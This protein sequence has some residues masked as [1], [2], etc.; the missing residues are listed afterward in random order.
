MI[1]NRL[2]K[3]NHLGNDIF[4]LGVYDVI[5]HFNDGEIVSLEIF[6]D[7]YM[8]SGDHMMNGWQI[9]DEFCKIHVFTRHC[10]KKKTRWKLD[11]DGPTYKIQ[12]FNVSW[13][14][15]GHKL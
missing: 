4:S 8:D 13:N 2:P 1:W 9:Q 11:K 3:A 5:V 7:I 14:S 15:N 10:R 6:K 12:T